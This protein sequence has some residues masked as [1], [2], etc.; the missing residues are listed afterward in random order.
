[1]APSEIDSENFREYLNSLPFVHP[2]GHAKPPPFKVGKKAR[3]RVNLERTS[4]IHA[5]EV[6]TFTQK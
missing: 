2:F 4:I 6:E 1:M 5:G 3:L